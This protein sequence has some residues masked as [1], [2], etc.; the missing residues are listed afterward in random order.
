[1]RPLVLAVV[2]STALALT[3]GPPASAAPPPRP[4]AVASVTLITGDT[5]RLPNGPDGPLDVRRGPGREKVSFL[6]QRTADQTYVIP[7]D[8]AGLLRDDRL[9][10]RLFEVN[11]LLAA[12]YGGDAKLGL[13]L[14]GPTG[15]AGKVAGARTFDAIDTAA[16]MVDRQQAKV[17]W[18]GVLAGAVGKVWLDGV[19]RTSLDQSVPQVGAPEAWEAGWTGKGTKVAVLDSGVDDSHPD[20]AGQV[21]AAA[22]FTDGEPGDQD[23]HGTHVASTIASRG[24]RYRGVAPDA[25]LLAG[26]VC[27]SGFCRESAIL[28]GMNWAAEQNAD[29]VNLSLGGADRPGTDPLEQA[30]DTLSEE[31]GTLFVVAA[32][33]WPGCTSPRAGVTSPAT[34][35]AALAVG[36]V[37]KADHLADFSCTGPRIGDGAL[38]PDLTAPG[39]DIVAAEAGTGGH[40]SASGTSMATPHVAGAAAILVQQHPDWTA[41]ELKAALMG[42]AEPNAELTPFQQGTGRLDVAAAARQPVVARTGSL[43][44]AAQV[45]PHDDDLPVSR[46]VGYR[47]VTDQPVTLALDLKVS[48]PNGAPAPASAMTLSADELVVPAGGTAEVTVTSDTSHTGPD[49]RYAGAL[50][51]TATGTSIV[52]TLAVEK[53]RE[54][55]DLT[56]RHLDRAG[57]PIAPV[58]TQVGAIDERLYDFAYEPTSVLRLPKGRYTLATFMRF[59]TSQDQDMALFG[60][61]ELV[62]DRDQTVTVDARTTKPISVT[63]PE[64]DSEEYSIVLA[65]MRPNVQTYGY[66][67]AGSFEGLA[68]A[69]VGPD[70]APADFRSDVSAQI[71]QASAQQYVCDERSPY[72]Y[73]LRWFDNGGVFDGLRKDLRHQDVAA[74]ETRY[75]QANADHLTATSYAALPVHAAPEF[76]G[77]LTGFNT[78]F[79]PPRSLVE[80]FQPDGVRWYRAL[81]QFDANEEQTAIAGTSPRTF[82]AGTTTSDRWNTAPFGPG[83]PALDSRP[84]DAVPR[85]WASRTGEDVKVGLPL[86][87]DANG[88][89]GLFRTDKA[90]TRLY[91]D[92]VLVAESDLA[93]EVRAHVSAGAASYRLETD[94]DTTS[95]GTYSSRVRA[96]WTFRSEHAKKL[97]SLPLAA[98]R[99]RPV[100]DDE[101]RAKPGRAVVPVSVQ[102]QPGSKP[103]LVKRLSVDV[104]YDD[105]QTWERGSLRRTGLGKWELTV[106]PPAGTTFVSLRA[107]ASGTGGNGVEQTIVR[108]YGVAAS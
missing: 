96:A 91:R 89:A 76:E 56:I 60:Q 88:R 31:H 34:A 17:L 19:R 33:N 51:A 39:V 100:V 106:S 55:Y 47:N 41:A 66:I 85:P 78:Y 14:T 107:K 30:I 71:C 86:H 36:A 79:Q 95:L 108:A 3:A 50:V 22:N 82:R 87:T 81:V 84:F 37:D 45:W 69:Q 103:W 35:D 9:D 8:A 21:V 58:E 80:Y 32:G 52:T 57:Q 43:S 25:K 27:E 104:S 46:T 6:L 67:T 90:R 4:G 83:F 61:P 93:G 12:G 10:R 64:K 102:W 53:E 59:E 20:L 101:G 13:I 97:A 15:S 62:L 48:G 49:G 7:T 23:G 24:E 99:F 42:A 94:A 105:G 63:V 2:V 26:K 65:M 16:V 40:I 68:M 72:Q 74:V 5:V 38:K 44:F 28:A 73:Y 98:V 29:V 70:V 18:S 92:G 75:D 1:M 54:S 11:E 77:E